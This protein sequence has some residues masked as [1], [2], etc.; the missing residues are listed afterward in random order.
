MTVAGA[1][2]ASARTLSPE[3]ALSR[4]DSANGLHKKVSGKKY[5]LVYTSTDSVS[6]EPGAYV[7][8]AG[9]EG[10][11]V[12]SADDQAPALLG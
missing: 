5:K 9:N 12:L 4:L 6:S 1:F 10:F 11:M 8:T 7:F 2:T 3:Q